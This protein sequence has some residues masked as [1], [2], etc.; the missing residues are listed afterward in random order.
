MPNSWSC[1]NRLLLPSSPCLLNRPSM[2]CL[3]DI[4]STRRPLKNHLS[5]GFYLAVPSLFDVFCNHRGTDNNLICDFYEQMMW[6]LAPQ[7]SKLHLR[8][9]KNIDL[10]CTVWQDKVDNTGMLYTNHPCSLL[11]SWSKINQK[12][13]H[14]FLPGSLSIQLTGSNIVGSSGGRT[15]IDKNDNLPVL[16]KCQGRLSRCMGLTQSWSYY[17]DIVIIGQRRNFVGI[18]K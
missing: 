16:R 8:T 7:M 6:V 9:I 3:T 4:F 5:T 17:A 12:S 11:L 10:A 2:V 13:K 1:R 18:K 14:I 15:N